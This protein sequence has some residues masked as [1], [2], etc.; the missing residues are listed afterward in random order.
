MVLIGSRCIGRCVRCQYS[1]QLVNA[2]GSRVS[3]DAR[4]V[5]PI[6]YH[7]H[8][9]AVARAL[10]AANH[11]PSDRYIPKINDG[12]ALNNILDQSM[13]LGM[14]LSRVGVEFRGMREL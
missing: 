2:Q 7:T 3:G 1:S 10:S 6:A 5:C 4:K 9:K 8:A 11:S 13:Y 12:G 14:S